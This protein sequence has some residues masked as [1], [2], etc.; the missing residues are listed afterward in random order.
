MNRKQDQNLF[1]PRGKKGL[2]TSALLLFA[3]LTG[4]AAL[5]HLLVG[6]LPAPGPPQA[7][8]ILVLTGDENRIPEG[9]RAWKEGKA[10]ELYILGAGEGARLEKVLPG[11]PA[12]LPPSDARK[13]HLEGWSENT[14]ENAYSAKSVIA[15]HGFRRVILVTSDYHVPRAYLAFRTILPGTIAI[16]VI[17]VRSDWRERATIY[18]TLRHFFV[19]GWKYW[20]YR[21]FLYWE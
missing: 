4:G 19:E 6:R 3:I 10:R 18:R 20:W 21:V 7:D 9:Y 16:E 13:L 17:P 1:R 8:A 2:R 12:T 5:P 14:L 15:E 11:R